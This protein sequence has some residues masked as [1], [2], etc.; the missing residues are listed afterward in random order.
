MSETINRLMSHIAEI[1]PARNP[2]PQPAAAYALEAAPRPME[3]HGSEA[4]SSSSNG[5]SAPKRPS[6]VNRTV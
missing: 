4:G 1:K 3:V 6:H 5:Q 2:P